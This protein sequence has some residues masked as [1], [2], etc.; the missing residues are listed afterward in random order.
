MEPLELALRQHA[1]EAEARGLRLV[2]RN[3][4]MRLMAM[5]GDYDG[6]DRLAEDLASEAEGTVP[7]RDGRNGPGESGT[8]DGTD[9]TA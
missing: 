3:H 7:S 4:A 9:E 2:R 1:E 5:R 6:L 8:G